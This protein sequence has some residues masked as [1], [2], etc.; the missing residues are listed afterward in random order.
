M[1]TWPGVPK[2]CAARA[3]VGVGADEDAVDLD[4][5]EARLVLAQVVDLVGLEL[6]LDDH[7]AAGDVRVLAREGLA[8]VGRVEPGDPGEGAQLLA[9][10]GRILGKVVGKH[11]EREVE[12][13]ADQHVALAV[14]DLAA[15]PLLAHLAQLV[16]LGPGE[17]AV[18]G[19]HLQVPEAEED[20]AEHEDREPG[21]DRDPHRERRALLLDL[22]AFVEQV[23][24]R[25]LD[26]GGSDRAP[27]A[28]L[29]VDQGRAQQAADHCEDGQ[30]QAP[31]RAR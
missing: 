29:I 14:E 17:I 23:H 30:R 5:G 1:E 2:S 10:G 15:R 26:R 8:D 3:P 16:V 28:G 31:C 24:Q 20:H 25:A 21:E 13:V 11:L 27:R 4:P 6:A 22:V 12:L 9:A 18:A 7:L 19:E